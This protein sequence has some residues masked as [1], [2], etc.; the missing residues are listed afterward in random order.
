MFFRR[1]WTLRW[2]NGKK[3]AGFND[4]SPEWVRYVVPRLRIAA[5]V[6]SFHETGTTAYTAALRPVVFRKRTIL[7][8]KC[9]STT[10][11]LDEKVSGASA[12]V[13]KVC[14]SYY[15]DVNINLNL[16]YAYIYFNILLFFY[17]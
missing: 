5:V 17:I 11:S 16:L 7:I 1:V 12:W 13:A 8:S 9:R 14:R 6:V 15:I 3:M 10:V 4:R 2:W